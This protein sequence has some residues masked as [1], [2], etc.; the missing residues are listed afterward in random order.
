[1][2]LFHELKRR[3]VLRVA[4]AYIVTSWLLIQVAE[5]IFPLF[6]F[7]DTP[8]RLVV[9]VLAVGFIPSMVLAWV[10]EFTP[11]GLKKDRDVDRSK[12]RSVLAKQKL[13]RVIML[14]L[15]LALAYFAFDKFVL[16]ESRE[17]TIAESARREGR[18]EA[19]VESY[20]DKSIAV[21]PFVNMSSD[22]E[23]EYF[24]D[25]ISEELLNLL[26]RIPA[27]RVISRSSAFSYKGKDINLA[28]VA[29]ELNVAHIL[30]GSVRKSGNQV[31]ITVQLIEAHSDTHLWSETYDRKLVDIFAIQDEIASIVV[32]QLKVTLL[33]AVPRV[34]ETDLEAYTLYLQAEHFAGLVTPE[35]MNKAV[36]L[37][38]RVL[39]I[40]PAYTNA[41]NGLSIVYFNQS[42]RSLPWGEGLRLA[43]EAALKALSLD[44]EISDVHRN[45]GWI[46]IFY[47]G[48]FVAAARHFERAISLPP[49]DLSELS[50]AASMFQ[51]L[52]RFDEAIAFR[53]YLVARNP[54][55]ASYFYNLGVSLTFANRLDDA[56][57]SYR[58]ALT[59]SPNMV[60]ASS[61][62]GIALM[63]KGDPDAALVVA[64]NAPED[65]WGLAVMSM[66]YHTLGRVAES[67]AVL[68]RLIEST[69]DSELIRANI[70]AYRRES[71]QAFSLLNAEYER[72]GKGPFHSVAGDPLFT[73]LHADPRW[74]P[75]L[76]KIGRSP[77]QLAAIK[78]EVTLPD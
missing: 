68:A 10:F 42:G 76:E 75:F 45:L 73:N 5:T 77:E 38:Q 78:F 70:H 44:S 43:Q 14:V 1:M 28:Q 39:G 66:A 29:A 21:L 24:S 51:F 27:L 62:V 47:E 55:K 7:G 11:E 67:E 50:Y 48:D 31:R 18:T 37:Y 35:S 72:N 65:D 22:G 34:Q 15:A 25:G 36:G 71:D 8:A 26:A 64:Q 57:A 23:Q 3:N 2:S 59:L 60:D 13:D 40:D 63:L 30:E 32:E 12:P 46:A 56:I 61:N 16:S 69:D 20:G 52:T 17:A 33:G 49:S 9:I 58:T 54:V 53:E 41:W 4:A 74:I 6:G 19:L